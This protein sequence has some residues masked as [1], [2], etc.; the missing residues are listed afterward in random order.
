MPLFLNAADGQGLVPHL[1]GAGLGH[2]EQI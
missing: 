2:G 1:Q